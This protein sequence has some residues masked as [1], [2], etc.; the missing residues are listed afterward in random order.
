[1]KLS[2][3]QQIF[4]VNQAKL[5]LYMNEKGYGCT[6]GEAW[7][8]PEMASI[9]AANGKGIKNSLHCIR[10]AIDIN[11]WKDGVYL[12]TEEPHRQFGEYWETLHENNRWGGRFGDANHYEMR[13]AV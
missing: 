13:E 4:A 1:M 3:K 2:E 5:I 10:L 12:T 11:L 7:R 9:Y 6:L 8:T